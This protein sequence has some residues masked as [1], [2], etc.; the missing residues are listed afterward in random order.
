MKKILLI[1]I[2][3]LSIN[4][5]AQDKEYFE[6]I[7]NLKSTDEAI[8]IGWEI[9][10]LM[11]DKY[12]LQKPN[13]NEQGLTLM[14]LKANVVDSLRKNNL[15]LEFKAN[16]YFQVNFTKKM[17]GE[18]YALEIKG[19]PIY[20]FYSV[21]FKYLDLYP[22]WQKYFRPDTTK[23]SVVETKNLSQR[24]SEIHTNDI[25][26]N[27]HFDADKDGFWTLKRFY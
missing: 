9:A 13:E 21:T 7:R 1:L 3:F 25:W 26:W 22:Y 10:N 11:R 24:K 20:S 14:F 8:K 17:E 15:K 23:E 2:A 4:S 18:N 12:V 27:Y 5:F 6:K 16:D 19:T